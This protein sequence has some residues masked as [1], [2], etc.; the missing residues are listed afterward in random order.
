MKKRTAIIA[1]F[2]ILSIAVATVLSQE[3]GGGGKQ[4]LRQRLA[5]LKL[6]MAANR[7]ALQKY[8]W[9][10]TTQIS[11]K[12][13]TKKTQQQGCHY[14]PDG[15]VVKTPIGIA[16]A[17]KQAPR[18]LKGRIVEKKVGEMKDYMSRFKA[19]IGHY[20][21]PDPQRMQASFQAGKANLNRSSSGLASLSFVD[22]Y[23]AGDKVA[24][25]FDT[26]AKKFSS[27][28]VNSYLDSPQ[29]VVTMTNQ[30]AGLPDGTNYLQQTV[31]TSK[32]KEIV[33]TTTNSDYTPISQ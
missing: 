3:A 13:E 12:G 22:Y 8:Q 10:E 6:A 31:L 15:K 4:A 29:D 23:K 11:I 19:L 20:V 25:G 24:I 33:I 9:I 2:T 28:D 30:F 32:S 27:Y 14:G 16:E 7:A 26:A 1:L 18:G 5:E 17:P 21:P